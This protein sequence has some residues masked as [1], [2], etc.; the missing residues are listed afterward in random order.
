[1]AKAFLF[2]G[3]RITLPGAYSNIEFQVDNPPIASQSGEVLIIDTGLFAGKY[4]GF[5]SGI[6]GT[7]KSGLASGIS[8]T[9]LEQMRKVIGGG[10]LWQLAFPLFKPNGAN[11]QGASKIHIFKAATTVA[12]SDIMAFG[13]D[14]SSLSQPIGEYGGDI[15]ISCKAEGLVGNGELDNGNELRVGFG[16][17]M[18][19]SS[20][21]S[22]KYYIEFYRGSFKGLD[23]D[24]DPY[25]GIKEANS[26][27][28]VIAKSPIFNTM[29]TLIDWMGKD[30][31]F[32]FYFNLD[33]YTINGDGIISDNDL[34][35]FDEYQLFA[36]GTETY[37][38]SSLDS[39]L[40]AV[41]NLPYSF[42][43]SDK[44]GTSNGKH[45]YN[46]KIQIHINDNAKYSDD[47]NLVIA[48]GDDKDERTTTTGSKGIAQYFDDE[49]VRVIH[50]GLWLNKPTG[51]QKFYDALYKAAAFVGLEAGLAAQIPC[52]FK[53]IQMDRDGDSLSPD[54]QELM[55]EYGIG[56]TYFDHELNGFV[57]GKYVNTLQDNENLAND[58]SSTY[59]CQV[60]RIKG[61]VN[62]TLEINAKIELFGNKEGTNRNTL[63]DATLVAF[64]RKNLKALTATSTVDNLILSFNSITVETDGDAKKV[65][66]EIEINAEVDKLF[67]TGIAKF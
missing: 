3:K 66:Y 19:R 55:L 35:A 12:A 65:R 36:G 41:T 29:Q 67:F 59:S 46:T 26:A 31:T 7:H 28:L 54:D 47:K 57:V 50:S 58:D 15:N 40:S 24:G 13:D 11:S 49:R 37:S 60:S 22:D 20:I 23:S 48:G 53:A 45:A 39:V 8:F 10:R 17:K 21:D 5:G 62:K 61:Q 38:S 9:S 42:I 27:P 32:N 30:S 16:W 6:S 34:E 63:S 25:D 1:M 56:Y 18:F 43:L 4:G 51:G 44:Y 14:S 64:T 2:D 33:S 52:T